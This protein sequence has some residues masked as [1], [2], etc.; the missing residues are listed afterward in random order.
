VRARLWAAVTGAGVAVV[1][2]GTSGLLLTHHASP[3][4]RPAAAAAPAASAPAP[5]SGAAGAIPASGASPAN[6][7]A[8]AFPT[9]TA[10]I[11]AASQPAPPAPVASPASLTIPRIGVSTKLITLGITAQGEVQVPGTTTVAGWYTHSPRP[12]AVGPAIILGHVDSTKGPGVFYRLPE[13]H[14]GDAIDVRRS[15]GSTAAFDVTAVQTY[16][17][18]QF[19]TQDVYGPVPDAELRL[20]TCGGAFDAATGHYLSNIV[21]YATEA[22]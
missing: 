13:L 11:V 9:P 19:P 12:G 20:I 1:A 8:D 2:A 18:D 10:P 14:P 15:D 4:L 17:K 7:P 5:A 21:V 3:G 16:A 22:S 6:A